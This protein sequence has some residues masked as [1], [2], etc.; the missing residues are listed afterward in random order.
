MVHFQPLSLSAQ[1][2]YA[3]VLDAA[4]GAD[5]ARSVASLRG[6][7]ASKQIKGKSYWY[8]QWTE[9]SGRLRQL[10]VGPDSERVRA[11]IEAHAAGNTTAIEA[12]ARSALALGNAPVLAKHFKVVQ[13]LSDYGFFRAGGVLV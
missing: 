3:Q 6:S 2:A 12:L 11:L 7:F 1:T 5:I 10:Y 4:H 8:F 9:L 13:R